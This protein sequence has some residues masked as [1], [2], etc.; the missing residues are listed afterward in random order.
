MKFLVLIFNLEKLTTA[1]NKLLKAIFQSVNGN[2]VMGWGVI[3]ED[4]VSNV[5]KK[6]S[7]IKGCRVA[8]F[9]H[10]F[11]YQYKCLT[12]REATN[13]RLF[14]EGQFFQSSNTH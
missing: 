6:V 10:H 8:P 7:S 12:L 13:L 9:L 2:Q 4:V 3:L 14:V 5:V 1:T 11:Y